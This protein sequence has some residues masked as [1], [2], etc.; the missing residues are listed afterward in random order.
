MRPEPSRTGGTDEPD[1]RRWRALGITLGAGFM[2]LLDVSIVNV[3]LPSI[4]RGLAASPADVQWVVSGYALTFGLTLVAGGRLGDAV[5]RRRMFLIAISAFAVTS[6]LAGAAHHIAVLVA[7]RLLQGAAAGLLTPQNTGLIQ[8]LFRGPERGRAFGMFGA[9]VGI[10]TAVGPVLGGVIIGLFGAD[11]GWRWVFYVNVPIALLTLV[12]AL[13]LLP[14]HTGRGAV[15]RRLDLVGAALLG[16]AVFTFLLPLVQAEDGG[17]A[18]LWWLFAVSAL[19]LLLFLRWERR[20]A[21]AGRLPLLDLR[22]FTGTPG[23]ATGVALATVY[24]CGFSGIWLVL[25]VFFQTGLGYSALESGLA[26]TPFALGSA[27]TAVVAGRLVPTWGRR[28]T[29][30]GLV[31]V[32]LGLGA[33]AL[34]APLAP[35][36]HLAL[37]MAGPLLVAGIGGGAVISP[38][39]TLT[40][41]CVPGTLAGVAGGVLQTGQRIGTAIGTAVL[42]AALHGAVGTARG[43]WPVAL[44]VAMLCAVAFVLAALVLAVTELRQRRHR[45]SPTGGHPEAWR[46]G[47]SR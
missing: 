1:P 2:G 22:L 13:R 41:E 29:V 43:G 12:A 42:S 39:T 7:A 40:L 44:S 37:A 30:T 5:G 3:A 20:V 19:A 47:T 4:Q 28:L 31:L 10:S 36:D 26:V 17:L 25:A 33:V 9:T 16:V 34:I 15:G 24:F 21:A 23:Y 8:D 35:T 14:R 46:T 6:A 32:A 45:A 11:T 38:N 18:R 27:V